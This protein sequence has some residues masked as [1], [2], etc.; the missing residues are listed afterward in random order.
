MFCRS[1]FCPFALFLLVIVLSF[2]LRFTDS[3]YL[4]LVFSNFSYCCITSLLKIDCSGQFRSGYTDQSE[5]TDSLY[6]KT[7]YVYL[8]IGE[9]R[10]TIYRGHCDPNMILYIS[11]VKSNTYTITNW[12]VS[13][14]NICHEWPNNAVTHE[15]IICPS[16][17]LVFWLS[18]SYLKI[19]RYFVSFCDFSNTFFGLFR[20]WGNFGF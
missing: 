15:C 20:Q 17:M 3:D 6:H 11:L 10:T 7:N 8:F 18:L 19:C 5:I 9:S 13:L 14:S 16:S 12:R 1:L 4:P 2:I